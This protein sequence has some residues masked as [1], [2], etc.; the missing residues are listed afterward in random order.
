M[1]IFL[2]YC[3]AVQFL[4]QISHN[5]RLSVRRIIIQEDRRSV[6]I[7]EF[8]PQGLIPICIKNPRL[9][10]ERRVDIWRTVIEPKSLFDGDPVHVLRDILIYI[11]EAR[12]LR[13]KD[14]PASSFRLIL[15]GPSPAASQELHDAVVR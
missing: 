5:N 6:G 8:H 2:C 13:E 15:H 12:T 11:E 7:V 4:L 3:T 10:V 14:M 1:Q 9:S